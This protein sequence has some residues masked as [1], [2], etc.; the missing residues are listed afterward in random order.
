M[1]DSPS[2]E[3]FLKLPAELAANIP[4]NFVENVKKI[5]NSIVIKIGNIP[6][7]QYKEVTEFLKRLDFS[8][9]ETVTIR[10]GRII[11]EFGNDVISSLQAKIRSNY[12]TFR[13]P[14]T[15]QNSFQIIDLSDE[16]KIR[17][18]SATFTFVSKQAEKIRSFISRVPRTQGSKILL[19]LEI[20][21]PE[22]KK[23]LD[24][25][26]PNR[27]D[28]TRSENY[29]IT[30]YTF[31]AKRNLTEAEL[32]NLQ[33][34]VSELISKYSSLFENLFIDID[35][36]NPVSGF[37]EWVCAN[38][39]IYSTEANMFNQFMANYKSI[40]EDY[41]DISG[42]EKRTKTFQLI[43]EARGVIGSTLETLKECRNFARTIAPISH[44][45]TL[46]VANTQ[47]K[48]HQLREM[49]RNFFSSNQTS[50]D[51]LI[52][53]DGCALGLF[54]CGQNPQLGSAMTNLFHGT[55]P[56]VSVQHNR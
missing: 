44:H 53:I 25:L 39:S 24:N 49:I 14:R 3:L 32:S 1:V 15:P 2:S 12:P 45:I 48:G 26:V 9:P 55:T 54:V 10:N 7:D 18:T 4:Q 5:G 42:A 23:I 52:R 29:H 43:W 6:E 36:T 40:I 33:N 20:T 27:A 11:D 35:P 13:L 17:L 22:V 38:I 50:T 19:A 28:F 34:D 21:D 46:G 41:A 37:G 47:E 16:K 56:K 8:W 30:F 31:Y 51:F